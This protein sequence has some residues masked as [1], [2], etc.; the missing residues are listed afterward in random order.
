MGDTRHKLQLVRWDL[1]DK[2]R[3]SSS[4]CLGQA[5][6]GESYQMEPHGCLQLSHGHS[7]LLNRHKLSEQSL[8][9]GGW[10]PPG[11]VFL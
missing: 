6:E 1:M 9:F 2:T 3:H 8:E 4:P 7:V 5:G 11:F 10:Y